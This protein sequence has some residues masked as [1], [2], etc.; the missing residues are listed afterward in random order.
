MRTLAPSHLR[1]VQ[2]YRDTSQPLFQRYQIESQ[3]AGI[4]EPVVH[5]KSGGYIVINQTE[6][7]VAIDVNTGRYVGKKTTGRLEDT[8]LKTN[9]E[10]VKEIVRQLRL[11]DM[12][13][14]V[15]IDF[16]DMEIEQ[17][18]KA[19]LDEPDVYYH[20]ARERWFRFA[21]DSWF[22]A[23][24]WNG[25]WYPVEEGQLPPEIARL[26]PS[27]EVK[28]ERRLTRDEELRQIEEE[29]RKLEAEEKRQKEGG[30]PPP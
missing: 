21:L 8:I 22:E 9:L 7:L 18:K 24:L 4:H 13:G 17:N 25:Q 30:K 20:E 16:I 11:R 26:E 23:F 14:I 6:A 5:L 1:R 12:G 27:R 10:A 3:I 19:V 29:L 15:V 28:K 2:H